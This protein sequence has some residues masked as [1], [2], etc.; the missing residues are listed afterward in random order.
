MIKKHSD[1]PNVAQAAEQASNIINTVFAQLP[2][3][4]T[5]DYGG[6]ELHIGEYSVCPICTTAIAESQ[7]ASTVISNIA[8]DQDDSTVKEHLDIAAQILD[9]ESR[10]SILRAELHNGKNTE[11]IINSI[12]GFI[13]DRK[14]HDSYGHDH[15]KDLK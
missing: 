12:L 6:H 7:Q 4:E 13:Y 14:I 1:D 15:S 9:L 3:A 8:K 2:K 10:V 11:P 5:F